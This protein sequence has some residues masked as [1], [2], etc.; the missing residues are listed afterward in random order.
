MTSLQE[1]EAL[2][3][4]ISKTAG[5][6]Q[7][8]QF[9]DGLDPNDPFKDGSRVVK[10][11]DRTTLYNAHPTDD[12]VLT[13]TLRHTALKF[14]GNFDIKIKGDTALE[15]NRMVIRIKRISENLASPIALI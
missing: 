6:A 10:E 5:G 7:Q 8:I 15:Q 14:E 3:G 4:K 9:N 13:E 11:K 1:S 2:Q 12:R